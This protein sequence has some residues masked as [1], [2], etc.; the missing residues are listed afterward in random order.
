MVIYEY[1]F[2][3]KPSKRVYNLMLDLHRACPFF[4]TRVHFDWLVVLTQHPVKA[5]LFLFG[6]SHKP[7]WIY[8]S[9]ILFGI[10][11]LI[12]NFTCDYNNVLVAFMLNNCVTK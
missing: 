10:R 7:I 11:G 12:I 4:K 8:T 3:N 6:E 1:T 2:C 5:H 9:L